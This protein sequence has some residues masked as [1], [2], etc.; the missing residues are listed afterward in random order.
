MGQSATL[1]LVDRNEFSKIG[2]DPEYPV[3]N[4]AAEKTTFEKSFEGLLFL[5]TKGSRPED[6]S[7]VRQIFY[8]EAYIGDE[9]DFENIDIDTLPDDFDFDK[10]P[11]YFND[12]ATVSEIA[13]LLSSIEP[14]NIIALFDHTE[15]NE[16]DIEPGQVWTDD[17][18][19]G[20]TF[21]AQHM[22]TELLALK[23]IYEKAKEQGAY[24]ISHVD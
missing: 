16:H 13:D 14:G 18:R 24:I 9:I 1:F 21:S 8:P 5:I 23:A 2:D 4:I 6:I 11:L 19:D 3:A 15:L 10:Q 20:V 22:A 17:E 7:I 12:P